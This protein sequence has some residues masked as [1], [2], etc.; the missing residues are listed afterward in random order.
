MTPPTGLSTIV[1]YQDSTHVVRLLRTVHQLYAFFDRS[2]M[3]VCRFQPPRATQIGNNIAIQ[4]F[5][6]GFLFVFN[7]HYVCKM[8][9]MKVIPNF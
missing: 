7:T 2:V 5:D 9:R 3:A 8:H 4:Q 1:S 6:H